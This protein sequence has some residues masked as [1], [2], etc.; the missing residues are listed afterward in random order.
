M[1]RLATAHKLAAGVVLTTPAIQVAIV[2]VPTN[3]H[4]TGDDLLVPLAFVLVRISI[5]QFIPLML[6]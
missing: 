5:G 3:P 2:P 1:R 4:L 6:G